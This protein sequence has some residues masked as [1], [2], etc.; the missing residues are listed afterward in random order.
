MLLNK[1]NLLLLF[2]INIAISNPIFNSSLHEKYRLAEAYSESG[3]YDD[4]III[5][6]EI[7]DIQKSI[8]GISNS[9]LLETI[10]KIY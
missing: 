7:L 9:N 2:A 5:Y 1:K 6:E 10:K 8:F 3:L 4:A